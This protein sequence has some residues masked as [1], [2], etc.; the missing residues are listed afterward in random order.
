MPLYSV[1]RSDWFTF[2]SLLALSFLLIASLF[3]STH[4]KHF[5]SRTFTFDSCATSQVRGACLPSELIRDV[6]LDST[7]SQGCCLAHSSRCPHAQTH[8]HKAVTLDK[9][10][11]HD[12]ESGKLHLH[13][14]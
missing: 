9:A 8:H 1:S 4:E 11:S 6:A 2:F 5:A 7:K 14:H 3:R 10:K 13:R 12:T